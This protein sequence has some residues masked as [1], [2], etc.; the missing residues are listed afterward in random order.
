MRASLHVG[1]IL[2]Y[3]GR[4]VCLV[5]GFC[6]IW[7]GVLDIVCAFSNG[8]YNDYVGIELDVLCVFIGWFRA[9][10]FWML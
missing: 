10:N 4:F 3:W 2:H 6:A 1:A 8:R 9:V 7:S 5:V